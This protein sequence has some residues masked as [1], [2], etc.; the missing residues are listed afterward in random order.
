MKEI[1]EIIASEKINEIE[2]LLNDSYLYFK[3][4]IWF[5]GDTIC[6]ICNPKDVLDFHFKDGKWT[7][8]MNI[9]VCYDHLLT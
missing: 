2:D 3:K 4:I 5:Y 8:E 9:S 1:K 7:E 6:A